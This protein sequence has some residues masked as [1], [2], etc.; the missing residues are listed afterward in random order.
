MTQWIQSPEH[1]AYVKQ[2][3]ARQRALRRSLRA[4]EGYAFFRWRCLAYAP[5]QLGPANIH[6]QDYLR[7]F[8]SWRYMQDQ[9]FLKALVEA[10]WRN[11][12]RNRVSVETPR[13]R[14]RR[15]LG[16]SVSR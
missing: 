16:R 13:L 7:S 15:R 3:R 10:R 2:D 4:T 8:R 11:A 9:A 1:L 6:R 5:F 14:V 12:V